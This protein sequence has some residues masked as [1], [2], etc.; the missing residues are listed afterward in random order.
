MN[1][2]S[3]GL[4]TIQEY[5]ELGAAQGVSPFIATFDGGAFSNLAQPGSAP[6]L[7]ALQATMMYM[8]QYR[9]FPTHN[10]VVMNFVVDIDPS[11]AEHAGIRWYELRQANDG[12]PWSV[13]QEGTYAPD[14]S[15]RFSGSI[16]M[17]REGNIGLG[18]Y[19]SG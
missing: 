4:S 2:T 10:S 18:I 1:W 12:E 6:D 5:Q 17:D 16:G 19:S 7:D 3:P 9:R 14:K 13:F 15:D 11:A 8:T